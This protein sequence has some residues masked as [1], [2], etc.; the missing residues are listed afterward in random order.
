M[1]LGLGRERLE[2]LSLV[3]AILILHRLPLSEQLDR[4]GMFLTKGIVYARQPG[5]QAAFSSSFRGRTLADRRLSMTYS[6]VSHSTDERRE[7]RWPCQSRDL[8]L[9]VLCR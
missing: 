8:M 4:G 5:L 7:R 9:T 3:A 2:S 6:V 1:F